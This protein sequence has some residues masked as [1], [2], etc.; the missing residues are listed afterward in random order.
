M[1]RWRVGKIFI[2]YNIILYIINFVLPVL[3][4]FTYS[5]EN[6]ILNNWIPNSSL[7]LY[8][9][10]SAIQKVP[11]SSK[12]IDLASP[13]FFQ[14]EPLAPP[15]FAT[16]K[17]EHLQ[18]AMFIYLR[19]HRK[20]LWLRSLTS[21]QTKH[22]CRNRHCEQAPMSQSTLLPHFVPETCIK[23]K[24]KKITILQFTIYLAI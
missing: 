11:I 18:K 21:S 22:F 4:L 15:S 19:K 24:P 6:W 10:K 12:K 9:Q 16:K 8:T 14:T 23:E 5:Q 13:K 17:A 2:I 3:L 20:T 1:W 7:L